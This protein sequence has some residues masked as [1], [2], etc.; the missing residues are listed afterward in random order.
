M[1][2]NTNICLMI[3]AY[4]LIAACTDSYSGLEQVKI[5][6]V[7]PDKIT[8]NEVIPKSGAVEIIFSLPKGH[9]DIEQIVAT[10]TNR[11]GEVMEFKVSRYSSSILVEGLFGTD[12]TK[13]NLVCVDTSGNESEVTTV[14]A[15]AQPSPVEVVYNSI[16]VVPAFGGVRIDWN[17][18]EANEIII[19]VLTEDTL[20]IGKSSL[21]E[22]IDKTI[23]SNDSTINF[24]YIRSYPPVEHLFAF[25]VSDKWG[26][27][28]DTLF[29]TLVPYKEDFLDYNLPKQVNYFNPTIANR[30]LDYDSHGVSPV[31]GIQNDANFHSI[32]MSPP[33]LF[34]GESYEHQF[35]A[36][37]FIKNYNDPDPVNHIVVPNVYATYDLNVDIILSRIR[38]MPRPRTQ[39]A[40]KGGAVKR[41]RIWGTDDTNTERWTKFPGNWTIIGEFVMPDPVT[42]DDPT[43]EEI[44]FF[45]K[46]ID[47]L[48]SDD[49]VNP[50]ALP[51]QPLRYMR[52][53]LLEAYEPTSRFIFFNEL[54][55]WGDILNQYK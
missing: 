17:N 45:Y 36:Y 47:F 21:V 12:E 31:T 7:R 44:E 35:Y 38:V 9:P 33:S 15:T 52:L 3:F 32:A 8:V 1:K 43:P 41:L 30:N 14:T 54:M 51:T 6:S 26:N 29:T 25:V 42:P 28:S 24:S 39:W 4:L 18:S 53:E 10:Y 22:N 48:V 37:R 49:N 13:I 20:E 19:H 34:D 46:G 27:Y 23:Y 40:Y 16:K 55:M 2:N 5:D 50:N 11:K